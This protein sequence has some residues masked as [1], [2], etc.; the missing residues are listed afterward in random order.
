MQ[1]ICIHLMVYILGN[2]PVEELLNLVK[3]APHTILSENLA[4]RSTWS[5]LTIRNRVLKQTHWSTLAEQKYKAVV[6]ELKKYLKSSDNKEHSFKAS[7]LVYIGITKVQSCC[8]W[9][10]E[11]FSAGGL[12][13][14]PP[15]VTELQISTRIHL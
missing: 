3:S 8:R 4:W 14:V 15:T 2:P 6:N 9:I 11:S 1:Q 7:T 10:K 13:S 12:S 5:H